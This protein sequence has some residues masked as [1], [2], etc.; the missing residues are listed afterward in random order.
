MRVAL[1]A[2]IHG[3]LPALEAVVADLRTYAPDEVL[4]VGDQVNR[5]PWN[6]EVMDLIVA[7]GWRAIYGNHDWVVGIVHTPN[8]VSPFT[9]RQRFPTLWWTQ[10]TLRPEHLGRIRSWPAE[11][12]I[13]GDAPRLRL[14]H[15]VPGDAFVG[16]YP[17]TP[18]DKVDEYLR[19]VEERYVILAH[20]HR[21]LDR[22]VRGRRLWNGGSVGLPYNGDPRA[23]YLILDGDASGWRATFRAVEFDR[24]AIES[25]FHESGMLAAS[26]PTGE[27]HLRTALSGL[28]WSSDFAYWQHHH[29]RGLFPSQDDAVR[30]YLASHGP[31]RWAF[32]GE[33]L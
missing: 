4:L 21:P 10:E 9:D 18:S 24:S 14:T 12:L 13:E 15:G 3:N 22:E 11:L 20:T 29:A 30:A 2:D 25:K 6:N 8:N 7:E 28:P 33:G 1:L 27:L 19:T 5:V 26:G 17:F 23:Q 31:G 16:I 32:T